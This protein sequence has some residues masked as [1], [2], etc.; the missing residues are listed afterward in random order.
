MR[1]EIGSQALLEATF[2]EAMRRVEAQGRDVGNGLDQMRPVATARL[3]PRPLA[4]TQGAGEQHMQHCQRHDNRDD[5]EPDSRVDHQH[6]HRQHRDGAEAQHAF[7]QIVAGALRQ[8][9]GFL[10]GAP[11]Q[12]LIAA[13]L[14]IHRQ[15]QHGGEGRLQQSAAQ[16]EPGRRRQ[17]PPRKRAG[18]IHQRDA[19]ERG[20][21][22]DRHHR[23]A[24]GKHIV[25]QMREQRRRRQRQRAQY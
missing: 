13:F 22:R 20:T 14:A 25:D 3:E 11:E 8:P 18:G 4:R 17:E 10:E 5:D 16:F 2:R 6:R 9:F 21:N 12:P 7:D 23:C 24:R 1:V 15:P 19:A